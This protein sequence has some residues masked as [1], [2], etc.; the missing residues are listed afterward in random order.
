VHLPH[1]FV[2]LLAAITQ[3]VA[4]TPFIPL[5]VLQDLLDDGKLNHPPGVLRHTMASLLGFASLATTAHMISEL[6]SPENRS[7]RLALVVYAHANG[8]PLEDADLDLLRNDV[9]NTDHPDLGPVLVAAVDRYL[10]QKGA[11]QLVTALRQVA[12]AGHGG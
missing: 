2:I 11:G 5:R 1:R 9:L 4:G 12:A 7:V 6:I 10:D 3:D 8:I